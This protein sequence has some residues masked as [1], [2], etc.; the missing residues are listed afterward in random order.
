MKITF[1][2]AFGILILIIVG[3]IIY[4]VTAPGGLFGVPNPNAKTV[5]VFIH[6]HKVILCTPDYVEIETVQVGDIGCTPSIGDPKGN[7]IA[8]AYKDGEQVQITK[9]NIDCSCGWGNLG[10]CDAR[11]EIDL[12]LESGIY[13]IQVRWLDLYSKSYTVVVP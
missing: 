5:R 9:K 3:I 2:Q 4:G 10:W 13:N 11:D 8:F 6:A 1:W 7:T 12:C